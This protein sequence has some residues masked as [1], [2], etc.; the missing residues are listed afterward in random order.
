MRM[1]EKESKMRQQTDT[2]QDKPFQNVT[3]YFT[4]DFT[5][6]L[7]LVKKEVSYNSDA[8]FREFNIGGTNIRAALVFVEGLSDKDLINMHILKSLMFNFYEEYKSA[9]S[10]V[11]GTISKEFIKNRVL[12]ISEVEEVYSIKELMAK[13]LIGS[14][15]LLVD[16]LAGVLILGTKKGKTRN[17]EEPISEGSV[18]GPRVGF[19]EVLSDN[20]ALLRLHGENEGLSLTKFHVG[21]RAKKELVIAYMK[22]I[23]D[24]ELVE[25]VKKRIQKINIDN[26]PESGYVEQLIEDNYL[27]PFPQAQSTERPDR[28][29]AALMEGRVAILLDGT[30]FALI[31]PVT[32]SMLMQSPEDYYERWIPGTFIRLLRFGAAIISLF[33]PALYISFISFHP[34]LIPTKLAISI[35]GGREGVPFPAI[36][37]ALFM[38]IAIEILREAGLRLPKPIG[39]AMGI[40]GGLIIGQAA[41]EA[42]IISPIMVIVVAATAISSFA[43]PHYSTAIPLRILRFVAMFCAAIFGLY[44]VILF[45]LVLCSHIARLKSFGVPYASPAVV[46]HLSDWKDFVIRMPL[47]MMKRRPKMM[48]MKDSIRKG[49]EEE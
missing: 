49:S 5:L 19:T 36:I 14:T 16:G 13:V 40:V 39:S 34:G 10:Y 45:F 26:V 8:H 44:G 30:P 21:E 31:V 35:L 4:G 38:E 28:V 43:L 2:Y 9:P 42:G 15:A 46:Y 33:A 11:E 27:S 48:N 6:D 32:F 7:E 41:V 3:D 22:E 23:A 29:I 1:K 12:S 37:E 17:V 25:E 47:Q 18:R 24:S 20:T